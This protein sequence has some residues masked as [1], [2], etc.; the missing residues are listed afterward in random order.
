VDLTRVI[1]IVLNQSCQWLIIGGLALFLPLIRG[2]L[3]ISYA[4]AGIISGASTLTY[5]LMQVPSGYLADRFGPRRLFILGAV[6]TNA[7]AIAFAVTDHFGLLV[8]NQ[9]V[10]GVFR[11]LVFVPGLLLMMKAF[12]EARRATALGLSIAAGA[13]SNSIVNLVGP[14]LVGPLGWRWLFV[15]FALLGFVAIGLF[16]RISRA[17]APPSAAARMPLRSGIGLFRHAALW[18]VAAI[19][20]VRYGVAMGL[21]AWLPTV[22]VE[23]KG[24]SLKVAGLIVAVGAVVMA[25]GTFLGG[26]LSDRLRSPLL[27]IGGALTILSVTNLLFAYVE[28]LVPLLLVA[29]V[30]AFFV[31]FYFGPLAALPIQL[32]GTAVAGLMSG[33]GNLFANLGAFATVFTLGVLKDHTG[34]FDS[35]FYLLAILSAVGIACTAAIRSTVSREGT[36]ALE[37]RA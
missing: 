24:L 9:S 16:W 11:A 1:L 15:T 3:G 35:G 34:S 5:A 12:P 4:Q 13:S 8:A 32:F 10:S 19:Q 29:M 36:V 6:G 20:F 21:A 31:Q 22:I 33:F 23:D 17:D 25:P 27:V 26:L 2:D 30:S 7:L 37:Q 14:L 18:L 28:G